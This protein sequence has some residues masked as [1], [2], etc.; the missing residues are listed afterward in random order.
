MA[1]ISGHIDDPDAFSHPDV[2][3][4][5]GW[6]DGA[7]LGEVELSEVDGWLIF[8]VDAS[9]IAFSG[10]IDVEAREVIS[11]ELAV[12]FTLSIFDDE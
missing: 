11:R 5:E 6:S 7:E 1:R 3:S 12:G 9:G 4:H 10:E 2:S 8:R